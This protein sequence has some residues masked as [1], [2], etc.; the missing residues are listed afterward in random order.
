MIACPR[1]ARQSSLIGAWIFPAQRSTLASPTMT[2]FLRRALHRLGF[3]ARLAATTRP[4]VRKQSQTVGERQDALRRRTPSWTPRTLAQ[5]LDCVAEEFP[6]RPYVITDTATYTYA[7]MRLWSERIARGLADAGVR[8]GDHVALVMANGHKYGC[9]SHLNGEE[10]ACSHD[11]LY[12]RLRT[13]R[14]ILDVVRGRLLTPD[15]IALF[16]RSTAQST[17]HAAH[18]R[19]RTRRQGHPDHR[20]WHRRL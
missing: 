9:S 10:S 1:Q 4:A 2:P 7:E 15:R 3:E 8:P 13:E 14:I 12:D 5:A 19:C 6:G 17:A 18:G 11:R 16:A 20:R